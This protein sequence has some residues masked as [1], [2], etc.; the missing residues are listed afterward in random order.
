MG[1]SGEIIVPS[2]Q[3]RT[4]IRKANIRF[5]MAMDFQLQVVDLYHFAAKAQMDLSR[6]H[7]FLKHVGVTHQLIQFK[8]VFATDFDLVATGQHS[9]ILA[10]RIGGQL[11]NFRQVDNH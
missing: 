6:R 2:H 11:G 8:L 4:N 3:N 5:S 1:S 10:V 7:A 9:E